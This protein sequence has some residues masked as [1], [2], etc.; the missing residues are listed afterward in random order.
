MIEDKYYNYALDQIKRAER[1]KKKY[2]GYKDKADRH[3]FYTG[4]PYAER[5]EIFGGPNRRTSIRLGFQ[6]DLSPDKHREL[7]ANITP[8]AQEENTKWRRVYQRAAMEILIKCDKVSEQEALKAWM[9]LI[10]RNYI[11]ELIPE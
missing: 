10:G 6:V 7:Q 1:E 5:H 2:N 8:W 9:A 4:L 11:E 3:C